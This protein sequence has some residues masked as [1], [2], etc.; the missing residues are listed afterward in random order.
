M[1]SADLDGSPILIRRLTLALFSCQHTTFSTFTMTTFFLK[2]FYCLLGLLVSTS[3]R[4]W[5]GRR[6]YTR[7]CSPC[8]WQLTLVRLK[9]FYTPFTDHRTSTVSMSAPQPRNTHRYEAAPINTKLLYNIYTM[10]VLRRRRWADV[11][12]MLYKCFVF[13]G[14]LEIQK[15]ASACRVSTYI[16]L[17][18]HGSNHGNG[19]IIQSENK[20][21]QFLF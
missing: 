11:A 18:L 3:L 2:L 9:D 7:C 5:V 16:I 12:Y 1:R 14:A 20:I 4:L 8:M 13:A 6:L 21:K 10:L 17:N 19:Q 15:A